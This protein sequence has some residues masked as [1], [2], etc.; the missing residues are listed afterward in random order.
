LRDAD[1]HGC[2]SG[3]MEAGG[4]AGSPGLV[5]T[6]DGN[7]DELRREVVIEERDV[8]LVLQ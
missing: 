3:E 8:V 1:E 5:T 6:V 4:T 7:A 2:K